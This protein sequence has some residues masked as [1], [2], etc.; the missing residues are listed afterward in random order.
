MK[1]DKF[2]ENRHT[3]PRDILLEEIKR[4]L[5]SLGTYFNVLDHFQEDNQSG[6]ELKIDEIIQKLEEL[7]Y[8]DVANKYNL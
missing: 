1:I 5:T 7:K 8:I 6:V 4:L 3:K 2:Y